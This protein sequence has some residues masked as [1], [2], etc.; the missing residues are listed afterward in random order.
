[1][2]FPVIFLDTLSTTAKNHRITGPPLACD[3]DITL[4]SA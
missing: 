3:S 1:M 4:V 2:I